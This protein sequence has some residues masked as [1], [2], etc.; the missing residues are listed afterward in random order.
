[1][2][3]AQLRNNN[4]ATYVAGSTLA[5]NMCASITKEGIHLLIMKSTSCV[6]A[7]LM[8]LCKL[9]VKIFD[10]IISMF[11][12]CDHVFRRYNLIYGQL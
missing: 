4:N 8:D 5:Q 7:T 2:N 3:V 6:R 1:M 12:T 10:Y 11:E 9:M